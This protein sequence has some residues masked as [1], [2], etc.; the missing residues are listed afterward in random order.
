MAEL[1]FRERTAFRLD[2]M[3]HFGRRG[4]APVSQISDHH[5]VRTRNW[6]VGQDIAHRDAWLNVFDRELEARG[7]SAA[8]FLAPARRSGPTRRRVGKAKGRP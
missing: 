6:L 2:A 8:A 1:T 5:L 4:L 3:F 7:L